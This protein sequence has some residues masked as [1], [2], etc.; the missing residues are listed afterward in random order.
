MEEVSPHIQTG[1]FLYLMK[2]MIRNTRNIANALDK[3]ESTIELIDEGAPIGKELFQDTIQ[4]LHEMDKKGYFAFIKELG[5]VMDT[6]VE[7]FNEQDVKMLGENIVTI[8]ET[9]RN[10]SQPDMLHSINN[11]VMIYKNL[12]IGKIREYSV[13][14]AIR[15]LNSPDMKLGIGFIITFLRNMSKYQREIMTNQE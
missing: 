7:H 13:W 1:D 2:K 3:F 8:L 4:L 5:K 10:L 6:V 12:D 9:V 11:A 14:R 15:E